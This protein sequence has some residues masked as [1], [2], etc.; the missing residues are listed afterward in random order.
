MDKSSSLRF[1]VKMTNIIECDQIIT[2]LR[3]N[4]GWIYISDISTWFDITKIV[5]YYENGEMA[6][7]VWFALYRNDKIIGRIN[8]R[9]VIEIKYA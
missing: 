5:P 8:G 4:D 7:V 2:G 6:A 1:E 3:T 9:H